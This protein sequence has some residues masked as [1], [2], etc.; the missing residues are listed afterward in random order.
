VAFFIVE[1]ENSQSIAEALSIIKTWMASHS[2]WHPSVALIDHCLAERKAIEE[3]FP[4]QVERV[5]KG[6]IL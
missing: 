2:A 1:N 4:G 3:V 6:R 5:E